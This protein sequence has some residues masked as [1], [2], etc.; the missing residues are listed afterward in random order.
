[1]TNQYNQYS[2]D[3]SKFKFLTAEQEIELAKRVQ[4][5]DEQAREQMANANL[6][7]VMSI[8][9][10]YSYGSL[11]Q[12]DLIAY[13]NIGLMNAIDKFDPERG[14]RFSTHAHHWI[15][16]AISRALEEYGQTIRVP[17]STIQD[18]RTYRKKETEL[19]KLGQPH[20][21]ADVIKVMGKTVLSEK[22][23]KAGLASTRLSSLSLNKTGGSGGTSHAISIPDPRIDNPLD[24]VALDDMVQ[25][26]HRMLDGAT[27]RDARIVRMRFGIGYDEPMTL[28]KIAEVV[29]VTR[30]RVRQIVTA[31]LSRL[32][33]AWNSPLLTA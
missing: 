29:G 11:S 22:Y 16:Q 28:D 24:I 33:L 5:G 17:S 30:E 20:E 8:A 4:N 13:G 19:A 18:V 31:E 10:R 9:K 25:K 21:F 15:R 23:I 6:R 12:D 7:L 1:M 3:S 14:N 27:P 26:L 2:A 32:K